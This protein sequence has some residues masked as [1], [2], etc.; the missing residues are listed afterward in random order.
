MIKVMKKSSFRSK[1]MNYAHQL[2]N[3]TSYS[4]KRCLIQA[5]ELYKLAKRM[6]SGIVTFFFEKKDGTVRKANG[7]L[8][9]LP[10]GIT[11]GNERHE[12]TYKT[13]AYYDIDR[14]AF[15]CFKIENLLKVC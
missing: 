15:R 3:T 11:Y 14:Q 12:P 1:V 2:F 10:S 6:R 9:D 4:W 8:M 13:F 5:W 7:T